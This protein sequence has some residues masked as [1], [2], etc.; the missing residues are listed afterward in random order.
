MNKRFNQVSITCPRTGHRR[1]ISPAHAA[2]FTG[3]SLRTA[4]RWANGS[5]IDAAAS[6]VLALR[7]FGVLPGDAWHDFRLIGDRLHNI[8][9]G[10]AWQPWE[11]RAGWVLFQELRERRRRDIGQPA[12]LQAVRG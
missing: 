8:H 1:A 2:R 9:T 12:I 6:Q 10:E 7:V 3:R 4:Q 5:R 11:L